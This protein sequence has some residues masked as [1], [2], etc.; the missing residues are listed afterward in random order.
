MY[1]NP[2]KKP[3]YFNPFNPFGDFLGVSKTVCV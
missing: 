3:Q 2:Y 1:G